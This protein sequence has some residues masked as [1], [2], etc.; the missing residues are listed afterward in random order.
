MKI[1]LFLSICIIIILNIHCIHAAPH[2]VVK[3]S[4]P[5]ERVKKKAKK[6]LPVDRQKKN[7]Q[8][9]QRRKFKK[10]KQQYKLAF[11][12]NSK[13]PKEGNVNFDAIAFYGL[14]AI[15]IG[16]FITYGV[17]AALVFAAV[18]SNPIIWI[19]GLAIMGLVFLIWLVFLFANTH[20]PYG[21]LTIFLYFI[22][23]AAVGIVLL[24]IGFILGLMDWRFCSY[25]SFNYGFIR[26]VDSRISS[27]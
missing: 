8:K 26:T 27:K 24:I 18:L 9:K 25:F 17:G 12:K 21:G 20:G 19:I 14:L 7:I 22:I 10:K 5:V 1:H 13:R 15:C 3:D 4:P 2:N 6:K 23:C 16:G 11:K